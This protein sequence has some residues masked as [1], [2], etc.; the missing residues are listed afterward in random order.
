MKK[1]VIIKGMMCKH[2]K[3]HVEDALATL[4]VKYE[5]MLDEKCAIVEGVATDAEI[6]S[7]IT[8]AGYEVVEIK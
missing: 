3:K 2:C 5:V 1:T 7:A 8:E 6:I 4:S